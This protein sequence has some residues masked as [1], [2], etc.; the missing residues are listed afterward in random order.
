MRASAKDLSEG[1][2]EEKRRRKKMVHTETK[3]EEKTNNDLGGASP[4][5]RQCVGSDVMQR[6]KW[7]RSRVLSSLTY[8]TRVQTQ[9]ENNN[10]ASA[11]Y[12]QERIDT[13]GSA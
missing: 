5:Q 13:L 11:Y 10:C 7:R 6:S 1:G 9:K 2:S 4:E 3:K 8:K 12:C